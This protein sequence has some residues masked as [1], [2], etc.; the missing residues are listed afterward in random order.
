MAKAQQVNLSAGDVHILNSVFD[1]ESGPSAPSMPVD[2]N[3]PS[4]PHIIDPI[5]LSSLK[6]TE[7]R[8]IKL[9]ES[10]RTTDEREMHTTYEAALEILSD[11]TSQHPRY[12]SAYNNSA[13]LR[14]WRYGDHI[15]PASPSSSAET[16]HADAADKEKAAAIAHALSDLTTA[17]TLAT[18]RSSEGSVSPSQGKLLANAWTQRGAIFYTLAKDLG[19]ARLEH[20]PASLGSSLRDEEWVKWDRMRMEEE[21]SKCFFMAGA[22]GGEVGKAMAVV[23]NPYARLCGAIVREAVRGEMGG[24]NIKG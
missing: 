23:S 2:P 16:G 5:T 6:Q 15:L 10:C 21:G 11:L 3:L 1:P 17:I 9:I 24:V 13:Q 18:P 19:V 22:Y 20:I 8:A 4:D 14:R 7:I 12:A